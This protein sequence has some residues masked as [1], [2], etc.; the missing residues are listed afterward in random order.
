MRPAV[1]F[2]NA[3]DASIEHLRAALRSQWRQATRAMM[4][5]LSLHG[6]SAAQIAE[7]LGYDPSTV[8]RWIERFNR[9]GPQGLADHPRSGRPPLGGRRLRDRIAALLARPGPWTVARLWRYLQR[10]GLS[11]RTLYRRVRQVAIWRRPKLIAKGDPDRWRTVAAIATRLR[12]LPRGA[13]VWAADETHIHWLA[14][15][16][17]SWTLRNCRP[18]IATPGKNRQ[19]TVLGAL[20]MTTGRWVYRLGRRCAADFLLLLQQVVAAVPAAPAI[21]VICD[22][23]S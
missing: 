7:L 23:D 3:P 10:P 5:L 15:I 11:R 4:V 1:V 13:V 18:N 9:L 2:A 17:A 6:L 22:N 8:R 21:V 20:E 14:H 16:R 19:V 12:A